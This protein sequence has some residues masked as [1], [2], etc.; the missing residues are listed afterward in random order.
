MIN[1]RHVSREDIVIMGRSMGT[2]PACY[3]ASK[4]NPRAVILLSPYT[5]LRRA[6]AHFVGNLHLDIY[7]IGSFISKLVIDRFENIEIIKNVVCP[8]LVIHGLKDEMI[9]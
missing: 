6:A 4:Y 2:G 9:P 3:L 8:I 1:K 5:S 7:Y